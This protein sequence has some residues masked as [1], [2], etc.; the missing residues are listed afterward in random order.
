LRLIGP[1][2]VTFR[3]TCL[4]MGSHLAVFIMAALFTRLILIF[5]LI[6]ELLFAVLLFC[7][8][9]KI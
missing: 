1:G 2:I 5:S 6:L 9:L 3:E 4:R 8:K 7:K